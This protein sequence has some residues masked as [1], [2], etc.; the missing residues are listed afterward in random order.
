MIKLYT[1]F[2]EAEMNKIKFSKTIF[3]I[4][5]LVS[6]LLSNIPSFG[7]EPVVSLM[8]NTV[9][10]GVN[11]LKNGS[12]EDRSNIELSIVHGV[13]TVTSGD[14]D[15]SDG[16]YSLC[17]KTPNNYVHLGIPVALEVDCTYEFS[18]DIKIVSDY[19]GKAFT[20]DVAYCTNFIFADSNGQSGKNHIINGGKTKTSQWN[21]VSGTFTVDSTKIASDATPGDAK[22]SVYIDNSAG[23][24]VIWRIDNVVLKKKKTV[25]DNNDKF[26]VNGSF[27]DKSNIEFSVVHGVGTVSSGDTDATDGSYSLCVKTPNNY[28]HLG[29]PVALEV[30]CTYEF[31][32][33]IKIVSDYSGKAFTSDVAYC[34]NFIFADSNGQSGKN[35]I[36]NGGKTKTSQW[37]HVSGT[38]TVD[39]TKIASDAT[40]E[41]AKFSIY[42]DNPA[43]NGVIWRIDNVVL[44]K[45]TLTN[46]DNVNF[47]ENGSFE[48]LTH[49]EPTVVSGIGSIVPGD[50]DA[51]DGTYSIRVNG[52]GNY[53]HV[54][55]PVVL[56]VGRTY[57]FSYEVKLLSDY[58]GNPL[59]RNAAICTNFIFSDEKASSGK[60]HVINSA[61]TMTSQWMYISDTF[62]VDSDKIA[63]NATPGKATFSI[64]VHNPS[65]TGIVWLLDN[66]VLKKKPQKSFNINLPDLISDNMMIQAGEPI[67]MWGSCLNETDLN[68]TIS[69]GDTVLSSKTVSTTNCE[70]DTLLPAIDSYH[71]SVDIVFS[72]SSGLLAWLSNVAVGELWHFSGQSNMESHASSLKPGTVPEVN[73]PDIRVFNLSNGGKG[74]WKQVTVGNATGISAVAY[75]TLETIYYGLDKAVPVG[76]ICTA[77]GGR[78]MSAYIAPCSLSPSGGSNYISHVS[79]ITRL[80]LKGHFWYQGESDIGTKDFV[81]Y[82]EAFIASWRNAWNNPTQP[83]IF[84]QLPRSAATFPDWWTNLDAN[85]NPTGTATYNYSNVHMWQ[86]ETYERMKDQNVAMV[87]T[88]D[89]TTEISEQKSV[90]HMDAEDPL[91]PRNKAPVGIRLG[92]TALNLFYGKTYINYLCPVPK[93]V[94]LVDNNA[95]IRFDGA[96]GGL[97]ASDGDI[98]K[99]FEIVSD[100]GKFYSPSSAESVSHDTIKLTSDKPISEIYYL[101]EE[102][103][104]DMSKPFSPL[105]PNL[106]NSEN[107]PVAPFRYK[108]SQDDVATDINCILTYNANTKQASV[109]FAEAGNYCVVFADFTD[110]ELTGV[111]IVKKNVAE[112]GI[113]HISQNSASLSLGYGDKVFLWHDIA[114]IKPVCEAFITD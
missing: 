53:V 86:Y 17:V 74:E 109:N 64:Y 8:A 95:Y 101:Y 18:Y 75:K 57:E 38:F 19:S 103:F 63:A 107:L 88:I 102:H 4:L 35:H 13:G 33:D 6:M 31:S 48:D 94:K 92:N 23:N 98:S 49:I 16:S 114:D 93:S 50:I 2:R 52:N 56:E 44:K 40:P 78:K 73:M 34:T 70:F 104:V 7:Q 9:S 25:N 29:L 80:P 72:D 77:V 55:I 10:E 105:S 12:F 43:G 99:F 110:G 111:D 5:L 91:H 42:T 24:G 60:N 47:F 85:G 71:K 89:T 39:S 61:S 62:T 113:T 82:F 81:N 65:G 11:Y 112:P 32:Y 67:P 26:F 41:S 83:F 87:V 45:K 106:F 68:I 51:A 14:T 30:D 54:G 96:Y 36:I 58:N 37:N 1:I 46:D 15:A 66:V 79:H 90:E 100:D 21:H 76:G 3:V 59:T 97:S 20:S 28:V 27:E 84:V 69:E 22:F 108:I